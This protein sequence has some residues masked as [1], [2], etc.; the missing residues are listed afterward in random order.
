MT[1]WLQ[2]SEE[3]AVGEARRLA[4]S[5]AAA[6]NFTAERQELVAIVASEA[7]TNLHRYAE[8]GR[9]LCA[10]QPGGGLAVVAIDDGPGMERPDRMMQDGVSSIGS[11][12][13]GLGAMDRLS[14]RF[15]LHSVPGDGT[16][17][18][19]A[20]DGPV[21]EDLLGFELGALRVA[22]DEESVCGDNFA[23]RTKNGNLQALICDGIGHGPMAAHDADLLTE[24][25]L[26]SQADKAGELMEGLCARQ[27]IHRGAVAMCLSAK[28]SEED[29]EMVG[30]GN[31][32]GLIVSEGKQ[33]RVLSREG[34]IGGRCVSRPETYRFER[35][36]ALVLHSDGLKT[37][38]SNAAPG[39]LLFR[40]PLMIAAILMRQGIKSYD[41]ASILVLKR[42]GSAS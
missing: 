18:A 14:D 13:T 35:G 28:A 5:V 1:C 23:W 40:S 4:R 41:D 7:A 33:R 36:E 11:M 34:S 15:E 22:A 38:R 39:A 9:L 3:S 27:D 10:P 8:N 24:A 12:G 17:I 19:A 20:F 6:C 2:V 31:I 32:A 42:R 25:F 30:V 29:I 37:I 16:V 26:R 21:K